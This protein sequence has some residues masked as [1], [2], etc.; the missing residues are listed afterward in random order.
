[1]SKIGRVMSWQI[2]AD[3]ATGRKYGYGFAVTDDGITAYISGK[4][5]GRD[6]RLQI[7]AQITFDITSV[8]GHD[9]R[10]LARNIGG[11][12]LVAWEEWKSL[13]SADARIQAEKVKLEWAE[14]KNQQGWAKTT[15][16]PAGARG[17]GAGTSRTIEQRKDTDGR[18]YTKQEFFAQYGGYAQWDAQAPRPAAGGRAAGR[19]APSGGLEK[20]KDTDGRFYTKK[21][22]FEQY[23][24]F[25]EWDAAR[26]GAG[27]RGRG[28]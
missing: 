20:R 16:A 3:P 8:A 22:F 25:A 2:R 12:G 28:F 7:G 10:V 21:E 18:F 17:G 4:E 5:V 6:R 1:M 14:F 23:G 9:G 11:P 24:G 19:G 13:Q 15:R 26:A 27:G